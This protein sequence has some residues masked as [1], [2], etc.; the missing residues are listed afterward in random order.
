MTCVAQNDFYLWFLTIRLQ[1]PA[2]FHPQAILQWHELAGALDPNWGPA[3]WTLWT[4]IGFSRLSLFLLAALAPL[5]FAGWAG[6][7]VDGVRQSDMVKNFSSRSFPWGLPRL[8]QLPLC[9]FPLFLFHS[10]LPSCAL[11]PRWSSSFEFPCISAS[12]IQIL[13]F[14][15]NP[16]PHYSLWGPTRIKP[17]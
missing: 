1:N 17:I 14:A 15:A 3:G 2:N 8:L 13:R 10:P 5:D 4:N 12:S 16:F 7:A 6:A 11:F 9:S